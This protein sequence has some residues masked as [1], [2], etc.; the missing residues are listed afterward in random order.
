MA[1]I[2]VQTSQPHQTASDTFIPI[3][4][5][6]L[7]LPKGSRDQALVILNVPSASAAGK[8]DWGTGG[9][10]RHFGRWRRLAGLCGIHL[11]HARH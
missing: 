5:L 2:F 4:G 9:A 8:G 6:T 7:T 3:P 11:P 1:V 10:V